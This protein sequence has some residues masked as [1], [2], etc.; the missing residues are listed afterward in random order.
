VIYQLNCVLPAIVRLLGE[1]NGLV[2]GKK[3][4]S[5]PSAAN[6]MYV[7]DLPLHCKKNHGKSQ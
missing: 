6:Q 2:A 4:S 5:A 3:L 7:D 1:K